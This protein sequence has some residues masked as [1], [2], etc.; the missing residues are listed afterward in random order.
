MVGSRCL[1]EFPP[2]SMLKHLI[3]KGKNLDLKKLQKDWVQNLTSLDH[4]GLYSLPNQSFQEIE[5]WFVEDPNYLPSLRS[6]TFSGADLM[7]LPDWI[8]KLS[9]LQHVKIEHC[10]DL[11]SLP[12]GMPCLSKLQTLEIIK[13]RFLFA[14]CETQTSATL[15]KISH[16]PNII[17]IPVTKEDEEQE[18]K[19]VHVIL[20]NY[21]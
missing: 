18:D 17:L 21:C 16:I 13:C 6:I 5:N 8:C 7:A 14:E 3:F 20:L 11:S 2:L 1:I 4:I 10:R 15:P 19:Y 9:S 12:E